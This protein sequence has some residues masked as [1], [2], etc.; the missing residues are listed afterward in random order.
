MV[1]LLLLEK[2]NPKGCG[3]YRMVL[4]LPHGLEKLWLLRSSTQNGILAHKTTAVVLLFGMA[5]AAKQ[6]GLKPK[7]SGA[8]RSGCF[9]NPLLVGA[10]SELLLRS[11]EG[12][13]TRTTRTF[14]SE[15][16]EYDR[17]RSDEGGAEKELRRGYSGESD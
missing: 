3:C 11:D 9:S 14:R 15:E 2:H 16:S 6:L 8:K 10:P 5:R 1:V 4:L 7:G 13:S 12:G 17:P